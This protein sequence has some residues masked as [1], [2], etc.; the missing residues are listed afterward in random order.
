MKAKIGNK[1]NILLI[2]ITLL[3]VFVALANSINQTH[4]WLEDSD[5]IGFELNVASIDIDIKQGTRSITS[6]GYIYLGTDTILAN[7]EY[8]TG[9]SSVTVT[10]NEIGSGYYIRFQ[11]FAVVNGVTYNINQFISTKNANSVDDFI[12]NND[13]WMYSRDTDSTEDG[14]Q[15]MISTES[16]TQ[17]LYIISKLVFNEA[18]V[19]TLQGQ[20]LKLHLF[21][22]GSATQYANQQ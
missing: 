3:L 1:L 22:E 9:D 20:Y 14:Y 17:S 5:E 6:G 8:L 21:V 13:G 10:N 18:F 7:T 2:A 15:P 11:A 16:N 19:E 12:I 4:S